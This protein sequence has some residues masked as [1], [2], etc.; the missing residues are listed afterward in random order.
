VSVVH[1]TR[2]LATSLS[3]RPPS[4]DDEDWARTWLTSTE[5]ALWEK[6]ANADRRHAVEVSR[7]FL[8]RRPAASRPETA[9]ALLHDLGKVQSGLGTWGRVVATV[10]GPRTRRFRQY[11][12]H[13][14]IGANMAAQAGCDPATVALIRGA[15]PAAADLRAADDS[16]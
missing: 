4:T 5:A 10:V 3:R 1:L 9:G 11:R 7:C 13:E 2:R 16:T 12:D 14:Q 6:M 8:L 15:G